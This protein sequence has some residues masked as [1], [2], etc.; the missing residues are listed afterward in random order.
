MAGPSTRVVMAT[1]TGVSITVDAET[2]EHADETT[3]WS[4]SYDTTKPDPVKFLD[5]SVR[6]PAASGS[7]RT[8]K[9]ALKGARDEAPPS[10]YD[11]L[12]TRADEAAVFKVEDN[13]ATYTINSVL[14]PAPPKTVAGD[15]NMFEVELD[16]D[17]EPTRAVGTTPLA[18]AERAPW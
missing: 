14:A 11:L 10:L 17:G 16:V 13:G 15:P 1:G 8:W 12:W 18:A 7:A 6:T 9:L 2:E 4:L 3:E 5:G